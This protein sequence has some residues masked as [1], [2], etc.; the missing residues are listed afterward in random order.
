MGNS[1]LKKEFLPEN[2]RN[3]F[4]YLAN[5]PLLQGFTLIGGTALSLQI[6]HRVSEDLDFWT[7]NETLKK[8]DISMLIRNAQESGFSAELAMSGDKIIAAKIN[9]LDV[10]LYSQD[11]KINGVKVTFFARKDVPYHYFDGFDRIKYQD[12]SFSIMTEA[13]LLAMKS[14]VIHQRTRSRDIFDLYALLKRGHLIEDILDYGKKAEPSSSIECA[15]AVLTGLIPLDKDDEG[16]MSIG[17][18][19]SMSEV[20]DFFKQ[21][22][23]DYE[24]AIAAQIKKDMQIF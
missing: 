5:E 2:T 1:S 8:R 24:T 20:Y 11:Y 7:S 22:I 17:E 21:K 10:L 23:N 15:K 9:G 6:G 16:L 12:T 14:Y 13:G 18:L 19:T 3:V 4:E